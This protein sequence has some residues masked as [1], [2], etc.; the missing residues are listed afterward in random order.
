MIE[1]GLMHF[2]LRPEDLTDLPKGD[3]R[4]LAIATVVREHSA[5]SNRWLADA[6]Q[7]GHASRLSH[8]TMKE[9]RVV[10]MAKILER[11]FESND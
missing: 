4:K 7:L 11:K 9:P 6:L 10:Q 2:G 8:A 3:P 5:V 1:A